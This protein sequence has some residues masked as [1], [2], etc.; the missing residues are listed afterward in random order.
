MNLRKRR[1][2]VESTAVC[3]THPTT[4]LA[5]QLADYLAAQLADPHLRCVR[6]MPRAADP[7]RHPRAQPRASRPGPSRG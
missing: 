1:I 7:A 3:Q 5:V 6:G 2:V 4:H